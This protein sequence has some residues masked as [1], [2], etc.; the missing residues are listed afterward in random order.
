VR[1]V[2]LD[3]RDTPTVREFGLYKS[4]PKENQTK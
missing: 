3:S 2:I 1:L 4:S